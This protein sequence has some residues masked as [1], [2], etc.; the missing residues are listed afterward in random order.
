MNY[1]NLRYGENGI[2]EVT[3][4]NEQIFKK[5]KRNEP[6]MIM[7]S[8]TLDEYTI[9]ASK[10]IATAIEPKDKINRNLLYD[11]VS[12][13][14]PFI[15]HISNKLKNNNMILM[16]EYY[17]FHK[18]I[19]FDDKIEIEIDDK[20]FGE[21]KAKYL[22][23]DKSQEACIK[24]LKNEFLLNK[25]NFEEKKNIFISVGVD[26]DNE[27]LDK[28]N[29][30]ESFRLYGNKIV[31]DIKTVNDK[32][33]CNRIT[34]NRYSQKNSKVTVFIATADILF[35]DS[36]EEI[37]KISAMQLKKLSETGKSILDNWKKY[38]K[39]EKEQLIEKIKNIGCFYYKSLSLKESDKFVIILKEY[40]DTAEKLESA[41][42]FLTDPYNNDKP[43][44]S[45][46]DV[47]PDEIIE[48]VKVNAENSN[49]SESKKSK[50]KNN[51][52]TIIPL[53]SFNINLTNL[54]IDLTLKQD[55]KNTPP[56]TGFIFYSF[57][58]DKFQ[59]KRKEEAQD[60]VFSSKN[61]MP[62]LAQILENIPTKNTRI[63]EIEAMSPKLKKKLES[64]PPT[65]SQ[66]EAIYVA[67]NTPDIAI[68]QGPPGTGKTTVIT[69]LIERLAEEVE[70]RE[71]YNDLVLLSSFQHDAVENAIDKIGV[72]GLPA[73][74]LG[75]NGS[76]ILDSARITA[77]K[78]SN[79]QQE[80]IAETLIELPVSYI[81]KK[82]RIKINSYF[83]ASGNAKET[84]NLLED[85]KT[86]ISGKNL[87]S[88]NL[89]KRLNNEIINLKNESKTKGD[90][91]KRLI[92]LIRGLRT[93]EVSFLDDGAIKSNNLLNYMK[94]KDILTI[95]TDKEK[96]ILKASSEY[97]SSKTP[98]FLEALDQLK[99]N[100]LDKCIPSKRSSFDY[101][102]KRNLTGLITDI[103]DEV[104][105]TVLKTNKGPSVVLSEYLDDIQY[106]PDGVVEMLAHYTSVLAASCQ[107]SASARMEK[108][109]NKDLI[110]ETVIID[111]AARA[112][113]LDL[114]IPMS[115]AK[116]RIILVGDHR[117]LPHIV[118]DSLVKKVEAEGNTEVAEDKE[119]L[120]DTIEKKMKESLFQTLFRNLNEL[121]KKTG[122]KRCITLDK[123]FRTTPV[124]GDFISKNFYECHGEK[125]IESGTSMDKLK[126]N[127]KNYKNISASWIDVPYKAGKENSGQSKSRNIE[128]QV[129]A[130]EINS[131]ME[132]KS[133][134]TFGVITFYAK[135]RDLIKKNLKNSGLKLEELEKT[136]RL[137]IG[138]IDAFQGREF[139]VVLL[140]I[141]RSN[142]YKADSEKKRNKKYGFMTFPNRLCVAMS[143]QKRLLIAVGD[144]AM[145][146]NKN[147]EKI[148]PQMCEF[149][150]LCKSSEGIIRD[151][152]EIL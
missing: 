62:Q 94:K 113:P 136:N 56:E 78:W 102:E 8:E 40:E 125:R 124:L 25:V 43:E 100:L 49:I 93:N 140:S 2:I 61:P 145:F 50:N 1:S 86:D 18:E 32:L 122:V 28:D 99:D 70:K 60:Q 5:L 64:K 135:Q 114:L 112:T 128:A 88:T 16:I 143:R 111:E 118:N 91:D 11:L 89:M 4:K 41:M 33:I 82:L 51:G 3:I 95:L 131:L 139:D 137:R 53:T 142:K 54:S 13:N 30:Y 55:E 104:N 152:K 15:S 79:K 68:I 58:G 44:L 130:K 69:S 147:A 22:S 101:M 34:N 19:E 105:Q 21:I 132:E 127:L 97:L 29:V 106:D 23:K 17:K 141:T 126:H 48:N 116:R 12:V 9:K 71:N 92:R 63:K 46:S 65:S 52:E 10:N 35:T 123:Q 31:A 119:S 47:I 74:K 66:K 45:I 149:R 24:F 144:P 115:Q 85:V 150:K 14:L 39:F 110:Y 146:E 57:S 98:G 37:K 117:Q 20:I 26:D 96:N 36:A 81:Y 121:E 77:E 87:I 59:L 76:T 80:T 107:Q 109:K 138:S 7:Y 148:I 27:K 151:Y 6:L 120:N 108:I 67:L 73:I 134:L 38:N 42:K 83:K 133:D 129:I 103:L 90:K 72:Y 75:R 84:V